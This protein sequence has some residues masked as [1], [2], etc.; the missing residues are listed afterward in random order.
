[1]KLWPR[2]V[3]VSPRT[4][5]PLYGQDVDVRLSDRTSSQIHWVALDVAAGGVGHYPH[6]NLVHIDSGP[7]HTW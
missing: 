7:V 6:S 5:T 1:M 3:P 2:P 4:A